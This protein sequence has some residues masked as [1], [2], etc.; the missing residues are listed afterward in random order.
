MP[1]AE[2]QASGSNPYVSRLLEQ[3]YG[4]DYIERAIAARY[5]TEGTNSVRAAYRH[6]RQSWLAGTMA[7]GGPGSS[8]VPASEIPAGGGPSG[9]YRYYTQARLIDVAS[10]AEYVR[11]FTVESAINIGWSAVAAEVAAMAASLYGPQSRR[12]GYEDLPG[13]MLTTGMEIIAIERVGR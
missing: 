11:S 9:A 7:S 6:G 2:M 8:P 3:G 5:P 10:G 1:L 13:G 4:Q 12:P